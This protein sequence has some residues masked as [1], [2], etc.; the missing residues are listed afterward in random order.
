MSIFSPNSKPE[1]KQGV[2]RFQMEVEYT[3]DDFIISLC[4][5]DAY[6]SLLGDSAP[7]APFYL[8]QGQSGSGKSHLAALW[9]MKFKAK[10]LSLHEILHHS[11][12][13][14]LSQNT[15]FALDPF[16]H[17]LN[18]E[19]EEFFFHL[20]NVALELR[21]PILL[22]L[23]Q[24]LPFYAFGLKDLES[25]LK[26][27]PLYTIQGPDDQILK[28]LILKQLS[29]RQITLETNALEFLLKRIERSF[30]S[31]AKLVAQIDRQSL[32]SQR[33][34]TIPLLKQIFESLEDYP[35][36]IK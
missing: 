10:N 18:Q 16:P 36:S 30:E 7:Y 25:R 19:M 4:N 22:V 5:Q 15:H 23:P 31:C 11:P 12:Y 35:H 2:F 17:R 1:F 9:Q 26:A 28:F 29:D 34:V 33:K 3:N 27:S 24:A 13:D 21:K 32:E 14:L 8:L 6:Y 20:Y